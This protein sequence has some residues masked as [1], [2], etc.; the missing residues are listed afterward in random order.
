M[1]RHGSGQ[2]IGRR[3][4]LI[5]AAVETLEEVRVAEKAGANRIELCANLGEGG[6]TPTAGMIAAV[7][8]K[9]RLP[10]FVMIRPRG[11]GYVY[12]EHEL[13][14]MLRSVEDARSTGVAG[15]V[16]GVLTRE[17]RVDLEHTRNLVS[18]ASGLPVT[19]HRA[20]DSAKNLPEAL[21]VLIQVGVSRVLTSGGARTALEG[22]SVISSLVAQAR[23]RI[24]IIAG[25]AIRERNV[26]G[27][28]A[29][30]G[31]REVHSRQI[32]GIARALTD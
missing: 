17:G 1:G 32:Q 29:R 30:T 10:V 31:V 25:G 12:S 8:A 21:D 26:R 19:F 2:T 14:A 28:V 16:T 7:L 22:A 27:L 23:D 11:G 4:I 6:S 5:E 9:T 18:A 3:L 24:V 20:F 13:H 15:I